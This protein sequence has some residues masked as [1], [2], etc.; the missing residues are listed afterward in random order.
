MDRVISRRKVLSTAA[1]GCASIGLGIAAAPKARAFTMEELPQ[2]VAAQYLAARAAC[3]RG[4]DA[5]HAQFIA[6]VQAQLSGQHVPADQ[7]QQIISGMTCPLC[8]CPLG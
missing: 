1:L 7:Q 6:D 5:F 3:S 8:G 4:A 2:P